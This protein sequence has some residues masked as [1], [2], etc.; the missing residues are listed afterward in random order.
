LDEFIV[1]PNHIHGIRIIHNTDTARRVPAGQFGKPV[2]GALSTIMRS[3]KSAVTKRI[4]E[5]RKTTI[6]PIW[7]PNVRLKNYNYAD[8]GWYFITICSRNRENIFGEYK[9]AAGTALAAVRYKND[10]KLS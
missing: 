4:N 3:F 5:L 6:P 10:I 7:Q 9:D 8:D 1:M 2:S